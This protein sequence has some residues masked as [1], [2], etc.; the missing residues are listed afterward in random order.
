MI[1]LDFSVGMVVFSPP[2]PVDPSTSYFLHDMLPIDTESK[3]WIDAKC[4]WIVDQF[5]MERILNSKIMAADAELL[6]G[7]RAAD[8]DSVLALFRKICMKMDIEFDSIH[9]YIMSNDNQIGLQYAA[10]LYQSLGNGMHA[11]TIDQSLLERPVDLI[12]TLAHELCHVLLI[13]QNRITGE[14]DDHEPLTDLLTVFFGFG[15]LSGNSVLRDE[16][17]HEGNASG[18][19]MQRAGYLTMPMYGYALA[20]YASLRKEA[21]EAWKSRLRLDVR[22]AFLKSMNYFQQH[23][24]PDL[25]RVIATD[26]RPRLHSNESSPEE[27]PPRP[28]LRHGY[29]DDEDDAEKGF[30]DEVDF[31]Y[32]ESQED[33]TLVG[34]DSDQQCVY[35]GGQAKQFEPHPLCADC[36]KSSEEN[37]REMESERLDESPHVLKFVFWLCI[38]TGVL[39]GLIILAAML[40]EAF[41]KVG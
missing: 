31:E 18:W 4:S 5:G 14:E 16:S 8:Y 26:S 21:P 28:N 29:Y 34:D 24:L 10:G 40:L 38:A 33:E 9:F 11:I 30:E 13:G 23:G 27:S 7:Y 35:C 17:W 6:D 20:V 39:A 36:I 41:G 32:R 22:S 1:P 19:R 3:E 12:A 15:A 2:S 25:Y 37:K